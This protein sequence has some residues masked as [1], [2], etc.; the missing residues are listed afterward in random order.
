MGCQSLQ[1]PR[2]PRLLESR[3]RLAGA[4][5]NARGTVPPIF[6]QARMHGDLPS[7]TLN[8][9]AIEAAAPNAH[10][11]GNEDRALEVLRRLEAHLMRDWLWRPSSRCGRTLV[12]CSLEF[13][14]RAGRRRSRTRIPCPVGAGAVAIQLLLAAHMHPAWAAASARTYTTY[15]AE[16]HAHRPAGRSGAALCYSHV[17][18]PGRALAV[19]IR[20]VRGHFFVRTAD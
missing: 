4:E 16:R 20:L 18:R 3:C 12:A 11:Y 2:L 15:Q 9:E 7:K 8:A 14:A 13:A 1:T 17:R 5:S 10:H 6:M 19:G